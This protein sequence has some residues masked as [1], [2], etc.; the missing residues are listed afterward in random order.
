[1]ESFIKNNDILKNLNTNEVER[2]LWIEVSQE[3][4]FCIEMLTRKLK[5]NIRTLKDINRGFKDGIYTILPNQ[6]FYKII[7]EDTLSKSRKEQL[8][9]RYK[10]VSEIDNVENIPLCLYRNYRGKFVKKAIEKYNVSEKCVYDY[11]R[12]YW[13]GGRTKDS[14]SDNYDNCGKSK[15]RNYIKKP[16]RKSVSSKITGIEGKILDLQDKKNFEYGINRYYRYN[17]KM[18]ITKTF[19]NII[20]DN[21]K[22]KKWY[23]KPTFDQF[24]NWFNQNIDKNKMEYDRKG[25]KNYQNNV[26]GLSSDSVYESYSPGLRYQ[27]DST[28]FPIYLVNRIDRNLG[29]GKPVVYFA[30]DV[31]STKVTGIHVGLHQDSWNGY[32][33]LLYNTFQDKEKYCAYFGIKLPEDEWNVTGSPQIIM[34]DR[35]GFIAKNSD[36]L[37]EYLK[38][39][40][41]Y[42]PSYIGSAKGTV[43]QKFKII[44]YMIKHDLPGIIMNKYRER[45]QKDYRKDAKLDIYEFT[46]IVI[47]AVLERNAKV[48]NNYPLEKELVWAGVSPV[49]NEIWNWGIKNKK[50][51]LRSQ[52]EDKLR[53]YLLRHANASITEKGIQ[54]KNMLYTC[55]IAQKENLFS[56][57]NK[58]RHIEIAYDSDCM[59]SIMMYNNNSNKY[60]ECQINRCMTSNDIYINRTLE[61]IEKYDEL[62][63]V[64]KETVYRDANDNLF[65]NKR[66]IRQGIVSEA[67]KKS[68]GSKVKIEDIDENRSIEKA[69]YD[70]KQSLTKEQCS[71]NNK[72]Y[73]NISGRLDEND[74]VKFENIKKNSR[75][76]LSDFIKNKMFNK[77]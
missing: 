67:V 68:N 54:Y 44:E 10:I 65:A 59:N 4:C 48:M 30:V 63:R 72:E 66:E 69:F 14:L 24:Y 26:R 77:N 22:G 50:G 20:A 45:G 73:R 57:I 74:E 52:P 1:M 9:N 41:E 27:V 61:E 75:D 38:V 56:R 11:L 17:D 39:S 19:D 55:D 35:G 36:L 15:D 25:K 60:I 7:N 40:I 76:V 32:A 31:F 3:N 34:A 33:K 71:V 49:A 13:Q 12:R 43:E 46:Q 21:Y 37:V 47:E 8:N 29:I 18:P 64:K 16:G 53:Y 28:V 5:I 2:V 62:V 6:D 23:E 58:N 51:K 70:E 42:A